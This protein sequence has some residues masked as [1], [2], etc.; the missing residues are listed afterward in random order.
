MSRVRR[1]RVAE[2][3][4][5]RARLIASIQALA[6]ELGTSGV[7]VERV[8]EDA[9]ISRRTYYNIFTDVSDGLASA[10][11]EAHECLWAEIDRPVQA[12]LSEDR[13]LVVSTAIVAFFTAL[14]ARPAVGWL[15]LVEP[16]VSLP[17]A[18]EARQ[19]LLLHLAGLIVDGPRVAARH[20]DGSQVRTAMASVGA[21]WELGFQHLIDPAS[22][23]Q[24]QELAKSAI[25]AVLSP[26]VGRGEAMRHAASPPR[27]P[28]DVSAPP[29]EDHLTRRLTELARRTL[30]FLRDQPQASNAEIAASVGVT[31]AS[32]M[33]RHLRWL[34]E[35]QLVV[36]RRVGRRN[37]WALT[38]RGAETV[39]AFGG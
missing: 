29:E 20:V 36:V 6:L 5:Q 26:H 34:E 10:V 28:F 4:A 21:L 37:A 38:D 32:Q 15:C 2:P 14:E 8:C 16:A 3:R 17:R 25:L 13:A 27:L 31:H 22:H 19:T 39:S 35:E 33:S 11:E 30:L 18:R 9:G 12:V 24:I 7:T 1:S 23:G